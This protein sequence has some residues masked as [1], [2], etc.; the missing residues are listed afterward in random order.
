MFADAEYSQEVEA[1]H[2]TVADRQ[3]DVVDRAEPRAAL[4]AQSLLEGEEAVQMQHAV[5]AGVDH[6]ARSHG[7]AVPEEPMKEGCQPQQQR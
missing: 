5:A 6:F 7:K 4:Q 1:H 2:G 3:L